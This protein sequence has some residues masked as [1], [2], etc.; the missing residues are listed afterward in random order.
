MTEQA[1]ETVEFYCVK[2]RKKQLM[3]MGAIEREIR[4]KGPDLLHATCPICAT[5]MVK[6]VKRQAP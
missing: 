1:K 3:Y 4:P 5:K 2:C 6:F